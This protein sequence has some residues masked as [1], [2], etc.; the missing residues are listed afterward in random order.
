MNNSPG[1]P[2]VGA[3][4]GGMVYNG[5]DKVLYSGSTKKSIME[6]SFRSK[7]KRDVYSMYECRSNNGESVELSNT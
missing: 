3:K 2:T 7:D 1:S 4:S 5:G 6:S